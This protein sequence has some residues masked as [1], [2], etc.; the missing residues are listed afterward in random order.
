MKRLPLIVAAALFLLPG[1]AFAQTA[2]TTTPVVATTTTATTTP[3]TLSGWIPYWAVYDGTR[4]A[5]K[6]LSELDSISPF[7]Y[8]VQPDGRIKD[9]A[10]IDSS[11]WVRLFNSARKVGDTVIPT[12]MWSDTTAIQDILSNPDKRAD[13]E[14]RIVALVKREKFDGIDI[15]YEGKLAKTRDDFS[16]FLAELKAQLGTKELVCT[17]EARTPPADLYPA[18]KIPADLEYANDYAA[19]NKSCDEIRLLTYDQQRAD[20]TLDAARTGSPYYPVADI[21]WVKKVVDLALKDIAPSKLVISVPTYGRELSVTVA[22][23]WYKSY[24]QLWSVS[25]TYASTTAKQY[26]ITP[27]RNAGGEVSYSYIPTESTLSIPATITAPAGTPSGNVAAARALAYATATG[28]TVNFNL[29]WWSDATA[30]Q[31]KIALAKQLGLKG[32]SIFK[33][34]GAEDPALWTGL[35]K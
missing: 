32:V 2:A 5:A 8:S 11:D 18:G 15:D 34:D 9:L 16:T 6:H 33:I 20:L 19:L 25:D 29:V 31:Q 1:A 23:Q 26:G 22:P 27:S 21:D 4:D 3:L 35:V 7:A 10:N 17:I 13:H 14:R 28:T 12:I 24:T 30:I